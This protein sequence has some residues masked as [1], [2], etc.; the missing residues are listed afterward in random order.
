MPKKPNT[1]MKEMS[2]SEFGSLLQDGKIV[3][4]RAGKATIE[5]TRKTRGKPITTTYD[6]NLQPQLV[7]EWVAEE[8]IAAEAAPVKQGR[9]PGPKPQSKGAKR[10]RKPG[11]KPKT[12]PTVE[13]VEVAE[14]AEPKATKK[15]RKPGPKPK[16]EKTTE[17]AEPKATKKRRKP[18]PKPKAEK[19]AP[20]PQ[21]ETT[22]EAAPKKA[23]KTTSAQLP[24]SSSDDLD[25]DDF[26]M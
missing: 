24:W 13:P 20:A 25:D 21:K 22:P 1:V 12:E 2:A 26:E 10:G 16:A 7:H 18:G 19:T 17:A 3:K 14:A 15:R 5:Y 8:E 23:P 11:P 9:K 6:I 4:I